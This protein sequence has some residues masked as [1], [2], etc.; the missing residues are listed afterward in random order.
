[1]KKIQ[2]FPVAEPAAFPPVDTAA[3]QVPIRDVVAR[4]FFHVNVLEHWKRKVDEPLVDEI[5]F[6]VVDDA[7]VPHFPRPPI[8]KPFHVPASSYPDEA[9]VEHAAFHDVTVVR[10]FAVFGII[11]V[12]VGGKHDVL[13]GQQGEQLPEGIQDQD[14]RVQVDDFTD[15]RFGQEEPKEKWFH[16]GGEFR[17]IVLEAE[18]LNLRDSDLV[19]MV[20]VEILFGRVD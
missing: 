18:F 3:V 14:I 4:I 1:M 20:Y 17:H 2:W 7:L 11:H 16:R 6:P 12:E 19:E 9:E 5:P 10:K 13:G 8:Q 15:I